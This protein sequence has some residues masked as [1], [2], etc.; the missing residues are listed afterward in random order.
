MS[1]FPGSLYPVE[2]LLRLNNHLYEVINNTFATCY[3]SIIDTENKKIIL[4]K[5][6]HH[7]PFFWNSSENTFNNITSFGPVLGI[8]D[9]PH[10]SAVEM[11]YN[12]GDKLLFFTDGIVE[13]RNDENKMYSD[14]RLSHS[15]I[16]HFH[17]MPMTILLMVCFVNRHCFDSGMTYLF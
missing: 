5:A 6:G 3:Y 13:Q 4:A 8:T 14:E 1:R 10:Y 2:F 15:L 11:P 17:D 9:N 12:P 7:H 16:H